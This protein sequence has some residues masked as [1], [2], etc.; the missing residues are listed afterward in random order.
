MKSIKDVE[1]RG[2]KVLVRVDFNVPLTTEGKIDDDSRI[3]AAL[4]TLK[5]AAD[6][7][8]RLIVASHLGRPKGEKVTALSLSPVADRLGELMG[9]QVTMAPDCVGPAV[10]DLVQRLGPGDVALLENLRFHPEEQAND[11]AFGRQLG[12]LCGLYVN[13]AFAVSHRANASV[14]A[15]TAHVA[16]KAAG[17]LLVKELSWFKKAMDKPRRPLAAVVGGAKISS[18]LGALENMLRHVD[19]IIIGGAM[20]NTFLK[21]FGC[22]VGNSKVEDDLLETADEVYRRAKAMGVKLYLP[23][24]G[25][26]RPRKFLGI[27]W[28]W[29]SARQQL[30]S[31]VKL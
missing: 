29:I 21:S 9:K 27:G 13:D 3:R 10:E 6:Q 15:V 5:Y 31:T 20:A 24:A 25:F 17:M 7:G 28:P 30:S 18:K 8:A 12:R 14:V 26:A 22:D 4:P 23:K 2:Q 19:K 16:Q 11:D 1:L